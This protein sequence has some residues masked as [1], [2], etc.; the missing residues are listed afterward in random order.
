M[1]PSCHDAKQ[2]L[3]DGRRADRTRVPGGQPARAEGR[4]R[5]RRGLRVSRISRRDERA[6]LRRP[7][8]RRAG[9]RGRHPLCARARPQGARRAQHVSAAGRLGRVAG[10]GEPRGPRRRGRDHR[11]RSGAHA[12]RARALP[13]AAAAPVGAGLGDELRGD[14]LLSRA[15]RRFARGAAARAV[16]RAGRTGGREHAGRN[17]GV[18]L[19]QSVRDG[20][21]GAARCRR[22]QR[23]NRRTRAA[24]AR[25]RR[26][27]AG[28]RRRTASNRG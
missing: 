25:P 21:G 8:L 11:R 24:C 5:Q 15:L 26:R 23:A 10:G 20:R 16:A 2:P 22:M 12:L 6:Q 9:D 4:G 14:Q 7:E 18:R 17:R 3:R 1:E 28:R 13:G 27:C 19:R